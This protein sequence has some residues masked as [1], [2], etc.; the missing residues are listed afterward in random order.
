MLRRTFSVTPNVAL[1]LP[2]ALNVREFD[3]LPA[4]ERQKLYMGQSHELY[5]LYFGE[6]AVSV[7]DT[8]FRVG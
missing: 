6:L 8:E 2:P 7:G 5:C 1:V 3:N 4:H